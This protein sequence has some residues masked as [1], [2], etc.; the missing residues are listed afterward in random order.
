MNYEQ[1][2]DTNGSLEWLLQQQELASMSE[3]E[4]LAADNDYMDWIESVATN[5]QERQ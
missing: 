1:R 3:V 5:K 4:Q 2:R